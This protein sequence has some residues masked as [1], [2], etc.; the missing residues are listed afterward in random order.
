VR[1]AIADELGDIINLDFSLPPAKAT[2]PVA[3]KKPVAAAK[4]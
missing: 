2:A 1:A 4:K 3:P